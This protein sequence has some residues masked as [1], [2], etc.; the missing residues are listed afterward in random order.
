M[1][2]VTPVVVHDKLE[3]GLTCDGGF[4]LARFV[5]SLVFVVRVP[6]S[7]PSPLHHNPWY[8]IPA[9]FMLLSTRPLSTTALVH[10]SSSSCVPFSTFKGHTGRNVTLYEVVLP[11]CRCRHDVPPQDGVHSIARGRR[12]AKCSCR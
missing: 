12:K 1:G 4:T 6:L 10:Y 8:T 3:W 11:L 5:R 2:E 9:S 7:A